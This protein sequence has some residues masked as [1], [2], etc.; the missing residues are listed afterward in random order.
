MGIRWNEMIS[1]EKDDG[2]RK[3]AGFKGTTGDC[4]TRAI[5]IIT[6]KSYKEVY[7]SVCD[8]MKKH[9]YVASGNA[10]QQK[11]IKGKRHPKRIQEDVLEKHGFKKIRK[12]RGMSNLT[13]TEAVKNYGE[14]LIVTTTKHFASIENGVLKDL[15]DHR[16]YLW[17]GEYQERKARSIWVYEPENA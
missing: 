13:Y 5:A 14:N 1:Y 15:F 16:Y 12:S 17:F 9:G 6:K 10:R 2:G 3:D 8:E 7:D 4:L 11:H